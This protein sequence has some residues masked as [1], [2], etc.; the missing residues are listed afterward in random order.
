MSNF[1]NNRQE[2]IYRRDIRRGNRELLAKHLFDI[3]K[4]FLSTLC[5]G[6]LTPIILD[7]YQDVN[8]TMFSL[9]LTA[10]VVFS[11]MGYRVLNLKQ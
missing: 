4:I 5:L 8:W 3:S 10:S 11:T 2:K 7:T 9:G 1:D 6:T